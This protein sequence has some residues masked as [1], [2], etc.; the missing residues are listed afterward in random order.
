M[1]EVFHEFLR[2]YVLFFFMTY[3]YIVEVGRNTVGT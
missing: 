3:W 1:N 2:K